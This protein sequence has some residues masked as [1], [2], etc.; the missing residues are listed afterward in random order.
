MGFFGIY[1]DAWSIGYIEWATS[2][3]IQYHPYTQGFPK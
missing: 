2:K 3:S 1:R